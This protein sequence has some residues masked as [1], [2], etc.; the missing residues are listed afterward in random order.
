[1]DASSFSGIRVV[2]LIHRPRR[3]VG[4]GRGERA[5]ENLDAFDFFGD[6]IPQRGDDEAVVIADQCRRRTPSA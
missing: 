1:M 3:I 4:I 2:M 6:T 5:V